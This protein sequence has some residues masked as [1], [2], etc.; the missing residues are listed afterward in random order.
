MEGFADGQDFYES[1]V[2]AIA[3]LWDTPEEAWR[4]FLQHEVT[5]GS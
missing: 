3:G 1:Q 2:A 4:E 5:S